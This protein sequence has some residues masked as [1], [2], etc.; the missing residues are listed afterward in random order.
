MSTRYVVRYGLQR[1]VAS[2]AAEGPQELRRN[3]AVIVRSARGVEWGEVLCPASERTQAYLGENDPQG[4]ILRE[5]S[6]D[7]YRELDQLRRQERE[8]FEGSAK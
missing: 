6:P 7:D 1:S 4:R 3:S 8:E 2:F 5:A